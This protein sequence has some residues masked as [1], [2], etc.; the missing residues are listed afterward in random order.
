MIW[1]GEVQGIN[2]VWL[3]NRASTNCFPNKYK[4]EF[5]QYS[6]HGLQETQSFFMVLCSKYWVVKRGKSDVTPEINHEH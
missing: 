6:T 3:W 2:L 4:N 5:D 1:L